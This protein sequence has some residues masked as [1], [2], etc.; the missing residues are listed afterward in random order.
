MAVVA[1]VV[2]TYK[3]CETCKEERKPVRLAPKSTM[4]RI[5]KCGIFNKN[6]IKLD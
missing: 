1:K 6:G 4:A 2:H 5:C 3:I